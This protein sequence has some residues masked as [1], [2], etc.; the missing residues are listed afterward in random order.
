MKSVVLVNYGGPEKTSQIRDYV[1]RLLSDRNVIQLPAGRIYQSVLAR[2]ISRL[3]AK[4]LKK[5]YKAIG[6]SPVLSI[7]ESLVRKLN[8]KGKHRYYTAM[9]FTP[10][11]IL[12][13]LESISEEKIF[14][15]PLFPHFSRVTT[16]L[17]L[18]LAA[19]SKKRIYYLREY[20]SDPK[21]NSLIVKRI[22]DT[23]PENEKV[24]VLLS[25]HSIPLKYAEKGD[26]Y[27]ES[28]HSHFALLKNSLPGYSLFLF[29][30]SKIG[31]LK[32]AGPELGEVLPVIKKKGFK[33]LVLYPLS[34]V[35]DNYET[36][37][38][39]DIFYR[40]DIIC[41]SNLSFKRIPCLNDSEEFV[42]FVEKM[43]DE[44]KWLELV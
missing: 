4:K 29:F 25:A 16:G 7:S 13:V 43:T 26:P 10:P 27:L 2:I 40:D 24:A 14:I 41:K 44:E 31:P 5:N 35:V 15:F 38:E 6:G 34:F 36:R 3:R 28:I 39:I 12:D 19:K 1:Y 33:R 22:K 18:S 23:V 17:C 21:F 8:Q 32:W 37:F 9:A 11:Y 20:W 30:Q 42:S